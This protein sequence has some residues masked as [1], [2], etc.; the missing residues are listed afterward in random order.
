LN[1]KSKTITRDDVAELAG[2]APSTVSN[3]INKKGNVSEKL[4]KRIEWAIEELGYKPNL[5][6][7]S[8]ITKSSKHIGLI[9]DEITNPHFALLA[10]GAHNEAN[11]FG[12]VLSI[13]LASEHVDSVI[14]DFIS[15]QFDGII[16]NTYMSEVSPKMSELIIKSGIP[17]VDCN[18]ITEHGSILLEI[19]YYSG[20]KDAY[21]YL[22]SLGHEKIAY[23]SG[24]PPPPPGEYSRPERLDAFRWCCDHFGRKHYDDYI[25]LGDPPY[26]TNFEKGYQY[27]QQLL[28][29]NLDITAIIAV[30]DYTAIGVLQALKESDIRVPED[31][32]LISFDNTVYAQSSNPSLTSLSSPVF[33][34]GAKAV[35]YI[36][37]QKETPAEHRKKIV[38]RFPMELVIR[39]STAPCLLN[40]DQN[41]VQG[42]R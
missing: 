6:A 7:R 37:R 23:I 16:F 13:S 4:K 9:I 21:Y 3:V 36:V 22:T 26:F 34:I 40:S 17:Y 24:T 2:V 18:G 33:T 25:V 14:E 15:R 38:E 20:M 42:D 1:R 11:K 28:K 10:K 27:G 35:E 32:S 39:E 12:Y 5:I 19:D 29:R 30:N 31:I 41:H 8:L